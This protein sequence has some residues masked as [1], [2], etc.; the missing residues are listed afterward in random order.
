MNKKGQAAMEFLMTYGWAILVLLV[1]IGALAYFG[2]TKSSTMLPERTLFQAPLSNVDNAVISLSQ[3]T[4]SIAFMNSK[5][6]GI[7]IPR[8]GIFDSKECSGPGQIINVTDKSLS[9]IA[10]NIQIPTN[11]IFI[12][13][14]RCIPVSGLVVGS[15]FKADVTFD[16]IN[17][18]TSQ[19]IKQ[20]GSIEGKYS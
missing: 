12:V 3:Q 9:E 17:I 11:T 18:E 4:V 1:V 14:W 16:Y 6:V 19:T 7:S 13:T 15:K 8:T 5:S 10:P 20:T 2:V